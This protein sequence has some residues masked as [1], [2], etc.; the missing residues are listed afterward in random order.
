MQ[1]GRYLKTQQRNSTKSNQMTPSM[2]RHDR[3]G[4]NDSSSVWVRL[5]LRRRHVEYEPADEDSAVLG[6][7]IQDIGSLLSKYS[8]AQVCP[9]IV[10]S[11]HPRC[12]A[13]VADPIWMVAYTT[14]M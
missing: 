9:S 1:N 4:R 5:V 3:C 11:R 6:S 2:S 8:P 13:S 7:L 14:V 12:A 10:P